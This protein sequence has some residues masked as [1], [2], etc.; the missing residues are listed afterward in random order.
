VSRAR[1]ETQLEGATQ[2]LVAVV[3]LAMT[4]A[5]SHLQPWNVP[6][7]R[8]IRWLALVELGAAAVLLL[9]VRKRPVAPVGLA[10][11]AALATLAIVSTAWSAAPSL[12]LGR[13]ASFAA[14]LAVAATLA[15]GSRGDPRIGGQLLLGVLAAVTFIAL[16]G[17]FELWHSYDQAVVPATRGQGARYN[18]IGQ[19][20]NQVAMLLAIALPLALW[21]FLEVRTRPAKIV[22]ALLFVF[23]DGS[24][25]ASGSR[26]AIVGAFAG[27]AV[28]AF[29][30]VRR[31]RVLA[32]AVVA[33]FFAV[34]VLATTLP[35]TAEREPV[36][37][38]EFG[39][40]AP[41]SEFD[42]NSRLPLESEYGFPGEN[43]PAGR[44]KLF[45]SAGRSEAW[46]GA[47]ERALERP[48]LGFGFGMEERAFVDRYYLFVGDRIE[49]SFLG[50][51][52]QLGP[53]GVVLLVLVLG[54]PLAAWLTRRAR[55]QGESA[56]VAAAAGSVAAGGV[57]LAVP[58]SFL[59]SAGSPPS[60]PFW[61]SLFLLGALMKREQ[62]RDPGQGEGDQSE[63]NPP[64]G[65]REARLDVVRAEHERVHGEEHDD[66]PAR[67]ASGDGD[68]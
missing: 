60:A 22:A 42:L 1:L 25:V 48:L 27:C 49:N 59:T 2:G 52:L 65:H 39:R 34:N 7:V 3:V 45:F 5:A 51:L 58:Q 62:Q 55:L 18:G 10:A 41:L 53:L 40:T 21:A 16:A 26:G 12:T 31:R 33:A 24:L 37:N 56:R 67:A 15:A 66:A 54:A 63:Q 36:L 44:R 19:N 17:V 6:G 9:L 43:A 4:F 11:A 23:L 8:G 28:F 46:V 14:L 47:A 35:P 20:P 68:R 29:A 64:Q 61:L 57:V 38:P 32:L 13:A 50:M 30:A